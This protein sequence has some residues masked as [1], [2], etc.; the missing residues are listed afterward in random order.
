[1]FYRRAKKYAFFI[2]AAIVLSPVPGVAE[3]PGAANERSDGLFLLD[4][5]VWYRFPALEQMR[6]ASRGGFSAQVPVG[7]IGMFRQ[8]VDPS[9]YIR[10][11]DGFN[12]RFDLLSS[13]TQLRHPQIYLVGL[14]KSPELIAVRVEKDGVTV[15]DGTG[16]PLQFAAIAGTNAISRASSVLLPPPVLG[17]RLSVGQFVFRTGIFG[18]LEGYRL[19]PNAA[20]QRAISEGTLIDHEQYELSASFSASAG[21]SEGITW[22]FDIPFRGSTARLILAPRVYLYSILASVDGIGN[23]GFS[24]DETG[25]PKRFGYSWSV[26][27]T[28]PGTGTGVGV[29][30]DF[31]A[32]L[33]YENL[34]VAAS[35]LN[36]VGWKYVTGAAVTAEADRER[37][38][39]FGE[40]V[41]DFVPVPLILMRF[42]IHLD[43]ATIA[44]TADFQYLSSPGIGLSAALVMEAMVLES[45]FR[46]I[47]APR[48]EARAVIRI[49]PVGVA[50]G[51]H[52]LREPITGTRLA[53]LSLSVGTYYE[54]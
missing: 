23:A 25:G 17:F 51:I 42:P 36:L 7:L 49:G 32:M 46:F 35:L 6:G 24:I 40:H 48:L 20:L 26:R 38:S 1:M 33:M 18:G 21:L 41:F 53:G 2:C 39:T 37:L 16:N 15:D 9:L 12:A 22:L 10:D 29:R 43:E 34:L 47:D 50:A 11:R 8:T 4:P 14:P 3:T 44:L 31:G 13:L 27:Y 54:Q 19:G 28:Y 45:A 5:N 30:A 52:L